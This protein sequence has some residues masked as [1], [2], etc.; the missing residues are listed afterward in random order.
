MTLFLKIL[1]EWDLKKRKKRKEKKRKEKK[2]KEKKRKEKKRKEKKRKEKKRKEKKRKGKKPHK[3]CGIGG[4]RLFLWGKV[5]KDRK[6]MGVRKGKKRKRG[7]GGG[8]R[9]LTKEDF[10]LVVFVEEGGI[11]FQVFS[12]LKKDISQA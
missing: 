7:E 12:H 4:L 1:E 6:G 11:N 3:V 10:F 5:R 9:E 2:R 8:E